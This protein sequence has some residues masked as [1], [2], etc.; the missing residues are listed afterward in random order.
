MQKYVNRRHPCDRSD[1]PDTFDG[2]FAR[3]FAEN[4]KFLNHLTY[5]NKSFYQNGP[6]SLFGKQFTS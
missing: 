3:S 1:T 4:W 6:D 2:T 5:Y